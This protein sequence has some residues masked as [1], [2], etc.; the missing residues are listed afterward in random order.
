[1]KL[2]R[3]K[4]HLLLSY[5]RLVYIKFQFILRKPISSGGAVTEKKKSSS[6]VL[7]LTENCKAPMCNENLTLQELVFWPYH[8]CI[9]VRWAF[10]ENDFLRYSIYILKLFSQHE[11]SCVSSCIAVL[12]VT[13]LLLPLPTFKAVAFGHVY[14]QCT[15]VQHG[16]QVFSEVPDVPLSSQWRHHTALLSRINYFDGSAELRWLC[17]F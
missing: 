13:A 4:A 9:I 16:I 12:L 1:M 11:C 10:Q 7:S 14:M 17:W 5:I 8:I 6:Q 3:G 15:Y 2:A